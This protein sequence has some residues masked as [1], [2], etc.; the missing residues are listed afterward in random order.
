MNEGIHLYSIS[1]IYAALNAMLN[2]YE[3]V[4]TKYE[5][6]RLRL[7][8]INKNTTRI[9]EKIAKVKEYISRELYDENA[10]IL[11]RNT[12]DNKMDISMIGAVYPFAV[13][14]PKDKRVINTVEKINMTL[15]T[16]TGG[17]LRFEEDSYMGGKYPWVVTT[18]WMAMYYIKCN[19]IKKAKECFNF[20]TNSA[21]NLG[22]LAEQVDNETMKPAW[23]IGL[24]WS[25]AM[26]I[27][28]LSE[29]LKK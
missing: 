29:I 13:F 3:N 9:K 21:S 25:H 18:L 12:A 6:N 22:F 5:S 26:Y 4:K 23:A 1:S 10:K 8:Q 17:Y 27:I 20:V 28:V 24:G 11:K 15:R 19:E 2:I 7:E 14:M 16:F